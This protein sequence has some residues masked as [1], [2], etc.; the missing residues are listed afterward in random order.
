M[1]PKTPFLQFV[2]PPVAAA[3]KRLGR[4]IWKEDATPLPVARAP[5]THGHVPAEAADGLKFEPV[6]ALPHV[7]GRKWQQAWW[8]LDVP[9][10]SAGRWLRWDDRAEATVYRPDGDGGW[11]PHAGFDPGHDR[12]PL[13]DGFDGGTLL[14][15][16]VCAR[17]GIW[18]RGESQGVGDEGSEFRGAFLCD[19]DEDAWHLWHDLD[20]L[21]G[22]C[23]TMQGELHPR[24]LEHGLD[25]GADLWNPGGY[26]TPVRVAPPL[27]RRVLH[28]L[29]RAVSA[30]DNDGP[31][32]ARAVTAELFAELKAA[33]TAMRLTLTGHAHIDLVWKWPERV[34]DFKAVHSFA[35]AESLM[36]RYP[37]FHFGYSQPA[38]YEAVEGRS[39]SLMRRVR[40]RIT[41]GTWEATGA[42]YVESDTQLPCGEALLR[43][44]ELGQ[45][46][47]R[48]LAGED[49]KTLWLP[50]VFGYSA[51]L[52]QILAGFGVPYFFTTKLHW[53]SATQFPHSAFVWRGHDG[54]EVL[55]FIA[56][57][58]YN[59]ACEAGEMRRAE[60][61]QR[62][63]GLFNESL[64]PLGYG[65]G[66][67]GVTDTMLERARRTGD[68][69]GTPR[70]D[71]GRID[72]FF[73]RLAGVRDALPTWR[74]EMYLEFHRGVQ[75][76]HGHLKSAYRAAER[77]LQLAEAARCLAGGGPV[78][79]HAWKRVVF[80]QF[81]DYLPGS[82]VQEV[83]DEGVPE[84]LQIAADATTSA[85][86]DLGG[87][88]D[89]CVFNPLP[90][91][92]V[93]VIDGTPRRL[94]PLASVRVGDAEEVDAADV[95]GDATR[96]DNGR[97]SATFDADGLTFLAVDGE[98]VELAGPA[99]LAWFEDRPASYPA[100]DIDRPTLA[101]SHDAR[102]AGDATADGRSVSF[103][104]AFGTES[105]VTLRYALDP[106]SPVLRVEAE[107]DWREADANRLLKWVLPT[108]YAGTHA[109]YGQPFGSVLRSQTAND[110]ADDARFECP[111]SRWMAAG[112]ADGDGGRG[113]F[114]VTERTYGGGVRD[115]L[116]HLSLA[117]SAYV[118]DADDNPGLRD[119]D[120]YGGGGHTRHSDLGKQTV[121][122]AVGRWDSRSPRHEQPAAL[123][124]SLFTPTLR[125]AGGPRDCGLLGLDG[126]PTLVP[127]WAKPDA[128]GSWTLR[129]NETL[130]RAGTATLRLAENRSASLIDL[131]GDP[132]GPVVGGRLE[133]TPYALLSVRVG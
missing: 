89:D 61:N 83:Y 23:R 46:G 108:R 91:E 100:W 87:E 29:A 51:C 104:H 13:P 130:G 14:V 115:G 11:T 117:R 21:I 131:K 15:E 101:R 57:E 17:T 95:A 128:S 93:E 127:T 124:D 70:C 62:Q 18:V 60:H 33:P 66:G 38:S 36:A 2:A 123:A 16:S 94:P 4:A 41:A 43:S 133:V 55:G 96:L 53:S 114:L 20:V 86:S 84:L 122:F 12:V 10:G 24:P 78:D 40:S 118:T 129:L 52:P 106:A 35:T 80:A 67:G 90:I 126:C 44:V 110:I 25:G 69:A 42:M 103:P 5:A 63:A 102:R 132:L 92:R 111:L 1:L 82:S 39:P 34:G 76:T 85:T 99:R 65:D 49:S 81:H 88:G 74:G 32:A 8:R 125:H 7:W 119:F 68:L 19:R 30:Y 72:G 59:L 6:A 75:T 112:H 31:A 121:R 45:A 79:D 37:E 58:H 50:D 64:F 28:G 113:L 26:R 97:V 105:T 98:P 109:R 56:W 77:G 27:F 120:A 3:H 73:G 116:V 48:D 54:S 107:I 71:W 22:L 47:F 9:A